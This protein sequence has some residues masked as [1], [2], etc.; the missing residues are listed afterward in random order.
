[1]RTE[2]AANVTAFLEKTAAAVGR[3]AADRFHGELQFFCTEQGVQSPIEDLFAIAVHAQCSAVGCLVNPSPAWGPDGK[4]KLG[5]GIHITPQVAVGTYSVDFLVAA[6]GLGPHEDANPVI[7][8]LDGHA[9]H[10]KDKR[11]RSYEKARDRHLVKQGFRVL[12][13]T[14]SDVVADPHRVAYEVLEMLGLYAY[15][16]RESYNPADPLGEEHGC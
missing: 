9:F 10:D 7:V 8:E 13:Y 11:Q 4:P 2:L 16:S 5:S 14:G 3:I 15:G 12:H 1:M 6:V